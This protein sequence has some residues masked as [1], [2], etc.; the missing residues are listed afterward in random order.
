MALV[1]GPR[2][3]DLGGLFAEGT[4]AGYI[5]LEPQGTDVEI[6][7]FGLLP[8][9]VGKGIGGHLLHFGTSRAWSMAQ[10]VWVHTCSLDSP[11]ARQ[12]YEAR[13]FRLYKTEVSKV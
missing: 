9:A 4:P 11:M 2:R 8:F 3:G 5:A 10:R 1:A 12:N 6:A 7:Y 13:G